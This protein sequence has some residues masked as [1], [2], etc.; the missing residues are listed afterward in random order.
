MTYTTLTAE[1]RVSRDYVDD[2][3][4]MDSTTTTESSRR[5]PGDESES[6]RTRGPEVNSSSINKANSLVGPWRIRIRGTTPGVA[7][8][9]EVANS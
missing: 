2:N 6:G 9:N 8:L 1:N 7:V 3:H 5:G 4:D